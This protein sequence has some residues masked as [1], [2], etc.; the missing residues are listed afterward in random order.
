MNNHD[1]FSGLNDIDDKFIYETPKNKAKI[2]IIKM[3]RFAA[4]LVIFL[5][6]GIIWTAN[7]SGNKKIKTEKKEATT[8]TEATSTT[9]KSTTTSTTTTEEEI[10]IP[11]DEPYESEDFSM[12]FDS[13][14]DMKAYISENFEGYISFLPELDSDVYTFESCFM[15]DYNIGIYY[16]SFSHNEDE[17]RD[18]VISS[19]PQ[20]EPVTFDDIIERENETMDIFVS[21]DNV[22]DIENRIYY[23]NEVWTPESPYEITHVTED[24]LEFYFVA[25]ND[26]STEEIKDKFDEF[27]SA[28]IDY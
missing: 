7:Q 17:S 2:R 3:G 18:V 22:W 6:V 19:M 10:V 13:Y 9:I 28:V 8:T 26:F 5:L 11:P 23:W 24:G 15:A 12:D 27:M 16:I 20:K 4:A 25:E 21:K 1:L 14:D